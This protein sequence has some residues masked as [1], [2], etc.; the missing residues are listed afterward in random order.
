MC[1]RILDVTQRV[2]ISILHKT[3]L[4]LNL[5]Y[6]WACSLC[7]TKIQEYSEDV[8]MAQISINGNYFQLSACC[9]THKLFL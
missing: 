6:Y 1:N 3:V 9:I 5:H 8:I 4:A 7:K 2:W